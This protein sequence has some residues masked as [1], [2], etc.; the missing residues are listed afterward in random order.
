MSAAAEEGQALRY[1]ADTTA[2][3]ELPHV[4]RLGRAGCTGGDQALS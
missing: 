2:V 3:M 1:K 4:E